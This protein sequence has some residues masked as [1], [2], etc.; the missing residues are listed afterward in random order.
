MFRERLDGLPAL[1]C[2]VGRTRSAGLTRCFAGF[3]ADAS[4]QRPAERAITFLVRDQP[5]AVLFDRACHCGGKTSCFTG[6][7]LKRGG[8]ICQRSKR[9]NA[10]FFGD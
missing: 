9:V 3:R 5:P 10:E 7:S 6:R 2:A 8:K 4:N 1:P